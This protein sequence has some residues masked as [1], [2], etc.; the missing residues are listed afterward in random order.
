MFWGYIQ[1]ELVYQSSTYFGIYSNSQPRGWL[2]LPAKISRSWLSQQSH[3]NAKFQGCNSRN[4]FRVFPKTDKRRVAINLF[5]DYT[6]V[7]IGMVFLCEIVKMKLR[8]SEE[9][10]SEKNGTQNNAIVAPLLISNVLPLW[11][12]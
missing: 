3:R 1:I 8:Q 9:V 12:I 2:Q 4:P 5:L 11:P 7:P 10:Q 6:A